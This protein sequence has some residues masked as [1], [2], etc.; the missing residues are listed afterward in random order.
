MKNMK[1]WSNHCTFQLTSQP[2]L[3]E[4]YYKTH[5]CMLMHMIRILKNILV[6][7]KLAL[8]SLNALINDY[9]T[10]IQLQLYLVIKQTANYVKLISYKLAKAFQGRIKGN[11]LCFII[12]SY[13]TAIAGQWCTI[14]KLWDCWCMQG[15]Q[16]QLALQ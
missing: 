7:C 1:Q 16:A 9:T 5:V 14:Q 3:C 8:C 13:S 6:I 12:H 2:Y 15:L 4:Y 11:I 10:C